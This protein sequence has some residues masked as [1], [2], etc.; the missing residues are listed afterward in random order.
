MK[1]KYTI[2][3]C[4]L[5]SLQI[6]NA[7]ETKQ[8]K[9]QL[10]RDQINKQE[11]VLLKLNEQLLALG[12]NPKNVFRISI[13]TKGL[14]VNEKPISKESLENKFKVMPKGSRIEILA[15][16]SVKAEQVLALMNLCNKS[17]ILD[18]SISTTDKDDNKITPPIKKQ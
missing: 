6:S 18:V 7:D 13:T 14:Q 11:L 1:I 16:Q 5:Y 10:L 2:I 15:D 9:I 17:G 8:E 4:L 3:L 12:E